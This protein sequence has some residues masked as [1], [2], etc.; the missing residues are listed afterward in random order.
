MFY[1]QKFTRVPIFVK[2]GAILKVGLVYRDVHGLVHDVRY[3]PVTGDQPVA[4]GGTER[5]GNSV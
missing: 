5:I 3:L 2:I 1:A 4:T